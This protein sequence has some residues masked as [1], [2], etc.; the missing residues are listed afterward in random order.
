MHFSDRRLSRL[1]RASVHREQSCRLTVTTRLRPLG[2]FCRL[3][4]RCSEHVRLICSLNAVNR[5]VR[6]LSEKLYSNVL[7]SCAV[8]VL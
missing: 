8:P 4:E 1:L 3:S 7:G 2:A 6:E 5:K